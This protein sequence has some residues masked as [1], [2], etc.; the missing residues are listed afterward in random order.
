[1]QKLGKRQLTLQLQ[2]PMA[3]IPQELSAWPLALKAG[4][5]ELEYTFDAKD[6]V[7]GHP[8]AAAADG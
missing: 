3:A 5:N 6:A 2:E 4:G 1:M 8:D 7:F